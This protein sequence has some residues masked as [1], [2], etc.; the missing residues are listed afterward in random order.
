MVWAS[1]CESLKGLMKL[2]ENFPLVTGAGGVG[3]IYKVVHHSIS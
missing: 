3:G 1:E 2:E